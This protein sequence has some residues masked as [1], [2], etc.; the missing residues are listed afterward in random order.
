MTSD[1]LSHLGDALRRLASEPVLLV[2]T[3]FDGTL[4]AL[5]DDP[6]DA[7]ANV[8]S[9]TALRAI[10]EADHTYAAMISGRGLADLRAVAGV[11]DNVRLVGSHGSEF[12]VG[13]PQDLPLEQTRLRERLIAA[14][15]HISAETAGRVEEKP[16]GVAFHFRGLSDRQ[17]E[18]ARE[19]LEA[20]P[21][22]WEGIHTRSGHDIVEL[23]IMSTNKGQALERIR[24]EVGATAV[25]FLGDDTT[26]EDAMA[27]LRGPDVGIHVGTGPTG[28]AFRVDSP[29]T[30]ARI[31]ALLSDLRATWLSGA[32][33]L[34]IED[35]SILSDRRTAAVINPNAR[36]VWMC[37]PRIDS[38]AVF[39]ELIGGPSAG[40]FDVSPIDG[41]PPVTQHYR[42]G[43]MVLESRFA[44]FAVTDYMDVSGHQPERFASRTDLVRVLNGTGQVVIEFAPRLDFGRI[45]TSLDVKDAGVR[46]RGAVEALALRSSGDGWEGSS[47]ELVRDGQSETAR[48]VVDLT[49]GQVVLE[50][51]SGADSLEPHPRPEPDR[52]A[53]TNDYWTDRSDALDLPEKARDLVLRSAVT[54]QSLQHGPTGALVASV[55]TSLPEYLG[56]I[57]NWDMRYCRLRDAAMSCQALAELGSVDEGL[58]FVEWLKD[59]LVVRPETDRLAPLYS[60][61]GRHLSPEAEITGLSGYGGSRPVRVGNA[62]DMQ[63]Q[64]DLYGYLI[65]LVDSLHNRGHELTMPD[66]RLVENLVISTAH[67]WHEPDH[68]VWE[69]RRAPRHYVHSKVYSWVAVDRGIR[70]ARHFCDRPPDSWLELRDRIA[71]DVLARGW[72]EERQSFTAAYDGTDLDA[73]ALSVGLSGLVPAEDPRFVATVDAICGELLAG[74]TVY[75]AHSDDGLPGRR[76]G[77]HLATSWLIDS[78]LLIGRTGQ[79]QD[80]FERQSEMAGATGMLTGQYDPIEG[81]ALGNL[82]MAYSHAGLIF[83]A[84]HL[85][86]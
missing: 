20:G 59:V 36:L 69:I 2:A 15:H 31:L 79:A 46:V 52:Q 26:D 54:L 62:A 23:T 18:P 4:A 83:N 81:R 70:V 76:H 44:D 25:V 78:L 17:S 5:V 22:T 77:V 53:D 21:S 55:T 49:R 38:G 63:V 30:V 72:N 9:I 47:W 74:G 73:A 34:P 84:I 82:P 10:A 24:G 1:S 51:R 57:R 61:T 41:S 11:S 43:S 80:I 6:D 16:A 37:V 29:V 19:A 75:S 71:A 35:H 13:F 42:P 67:R 12:D 58:R 65:D 39:A 56:G 60:V 33:L 8:E 68:G 7:V 40:S 32:G 28:A 45:P 86:R 50:L 14:A 85:S 27:T 64:L 48:A 3:D 66:W